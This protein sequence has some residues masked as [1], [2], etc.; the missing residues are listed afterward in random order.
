M[1]PLPKKRKHTSIGKFLFFSKHFLSRKNRFPSEL[2]NLLSG[3]MVLWNL[4]RWRI[5]AWKVPK[6][7]QIWT[8]VTNQFFP[9][10]P[11][12][13]TT[14][15][16]GSPRAYEDSKNSQKFHTYSERTWKSLSVTLFNLAVLVRSWPNLKL[17]PWFLKISVKV[18]SNFTKQ[19]IEKLTTP[20]DSKWPYY[21]EIDN[22]LYLENFY[23]FK[24]FPNA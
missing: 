5:S 8:T 22:P 21:P 16:D 19:G 7:T 23:F 3:E 4:P 24:N 14:P 17:P 15:F 11:F 6:W 12:P 2:R 1:A 18:N 13:D 9:F 20:I 10:C